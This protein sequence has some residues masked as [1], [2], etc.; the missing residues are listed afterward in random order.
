MKPAAPLRVLVV[1]GSPQARRLLCQAIAA[2]A[3]LE[4]LAQAGDA[5][6]AR[7][8]L[9]LQQP[10]VVVLD[11][12]LPRID[13]LSFLRRYMRALPTPTVVLDSGRAADR[14]RIA[15][16]LAEGAAG[17]AARPT[18]DDPV[19]LQRQMRLLATRIKAA[20]RGGA[21]Q[22]ARAAAP[23]LPPPQ[24]AAER[25]IAVGS[26]TG[27]VEALN[28]LLPAFDEHTPGMV[29]VQHMPAGFTGSLARRLDG[30]GRLRV[31][32]AR[33]GDR[34]LQGQA[35]LAPGGQRHMVLVRAGAQFRVRLVDGDPVNY[36]RPS[37]DVLFESVAEQAGARSAAVLLTGMGRDGAAGMLAIRRRGGHTVAQDEATSV[38]FGMPQMARRL[39]AAEAVAPLSAIPATLARLMN[40]QR[41]GAATPATHAGESDD[42]EPGI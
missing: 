34:V 32:E 42:S 22:A 4:L 31:R 18:A 16:A 37:V 28:Q 14:G 9:V 20:A 2:D 35:L 10:D 30:L 3:H 1:D 29:I 39:G 38:V 13:G 19:R 23:A 41:P 11:L 21:P 17:V 24:L 25:V 40:P 15:Q 7:D 6:A 26:S 36:S 8:V 5:W 12:D 33:D 27:G